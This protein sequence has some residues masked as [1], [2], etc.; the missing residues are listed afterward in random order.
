MATT[1][2]PTLARAPANSHTID[3]VGFH[4]SSHIRFR[5]VSPFA[6][7]FSYSLSSTFNKGNA[8]DCLWPAA[9]HGVKVALFVARFLASSETRTLASDISLASLVASF[10]LSQVTQLAWFS[11]LGRRLAP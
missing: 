11:A 2:L 6:A 9:A 5:P 10:P 8:I 1:S 7:T 4:S 3:R